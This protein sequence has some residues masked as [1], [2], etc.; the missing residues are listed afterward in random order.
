MTGAGVGRGSRAALMVLVGVIL[1][2][3]AQATCP[4]VCACKWKVSL[5]P[6][7]FT[8]PSPGHPTPPNDIPPGPLP[9]SPLPVT[10]TFIP[11]LSIPHPHP[12]P[13]PS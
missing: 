11:H 4:R 10:F 13:L 1:V 2:G 8:L 7:S 6:S 3:G 5:S 12:S 9:S